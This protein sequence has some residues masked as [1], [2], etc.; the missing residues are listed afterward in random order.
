M[1]RLIEILTDIGPTDWQIASMVCQLL[2]NYS[3]NS[4]SS[5]NKHFD[6]TELILLHTIL[7]ELLG[8]YNL[9]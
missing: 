4:R 8:K 1:N 6:K 9:I 5:S 7:T 2:M 3:E